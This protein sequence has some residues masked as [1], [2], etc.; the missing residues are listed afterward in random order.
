MEL[1]FLQKLAEMFHVEIGDCAVI[2]AFIVGIVAICKQHIGLNGKPIMIVAAFIAIALNLMN[3]WPVTEVQSGFGIVVGSAIS[4][5]MAIGGWSI[6]K[7]LIHK[8]GTPSTH[9]NTV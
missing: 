6:A 8:A 3:A 9:E 2:G 1:D 5:G 7:Q 4:W